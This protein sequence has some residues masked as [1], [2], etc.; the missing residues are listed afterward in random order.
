MIQMRDYKDFL[1]AKQSCAESRSIDSGKDIHPCLFDFQQ[2]IVAWALKKGRC[3][4]FADCGLGKTL[5]QLEW[6]RH[7][8]GDVLI[9]AP[10]AVAEQTVREGLKIGVK[11]TH[12]READQLRKG[13]NIT[14]YE[15]LARF[16]AHE[17]EGV[18]LDES[19]ILKSFNG[20]TRN[21]IIERFSKTPFRLA[22]TATPAP[23]DFMELG[24]HSEFLGIMRYSEMLSMFF[25]HDGGET[26]KWRLKG[27]AESE[28]YK[29]TASWSVNIRRPED[30]E[31]DG[32]RFILPALNMKEHKIKSETTQQGMLFPMEAQ[33]LQERIGARRD[34]IADRCAKA[35]ELI[36]LDQT[37][38]QWLVWCNL[39]SEADNF[40]RACPGAVEV[41]GNMTPETKERILTEFS[42][43][44]IKVLVTKPSIAGFGMNWQNCHKVI[45]LGLSDSYEEFYQALRRC[46]RFGQL[47][48]VTAHIVISATEGAVLRNIMR[49]EQDATALAVGMVE[50]MREYMKQELEGS[51]REISKYNVKIAEGDK[52][53][54]ILGDSCEVIKQIATESIG[55]SV[56]S[57]PFSSLYTYS[58]SDRDMGNCRSDDEFFEH[59]KFLIKELYRVTEPGRLLSFHCMN[60]P[61]SKTHHGHIGIRDFRGDLIRAFEAEGFWYHSEV[62]IWKDPVTAMQRTKAIG[63]LHKQLKKDSSLSRQGVPDYLVTMRKPGENKKRISHTNESFPVEIWQQY[64]SPVWMDINPSD[65][66]QFRSAREH[67]DERHICPLQLTVIRRAMELWSTTD[68]LVLSPFAGIGSEGYVALELGRQFLGIELKESYFNQACKNLH[69]VARQEVMDMFGKVEERIVA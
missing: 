38:D 42:Q 40:I 51:T 12:V 36:A 34:S 24:N 10:L 37:K 56:F 11:V 47:S 23:N 35:A 62:C 21:A 50:H 69:N 1:L 18:V 63:L 65:T 8:K 60:L 13:I 19:S 14:N 15:R 9:L 49:K 29:W 67:K 7:I 48:E 17:F 5:M 33:G 3:A 39:N 58:N 54:M 6:A 31:C 30:L 57:P 68:D 28:F 43:G 64:A 16:D 27:H 26:Q 22:C 20:K 2:K 61:T 44:K 32:R 52:W 46:W 53:K 55:Y 41:R 59:F 45:F 4:I 66:I 25:V